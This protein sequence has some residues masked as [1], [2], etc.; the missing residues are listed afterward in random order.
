MDLKRF[1][2]VTLFF[3]CKYILGIY[4]VSHARR[5]TETK[6]ITKEGSPGDFSC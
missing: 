5:N 6:P 1:F 4:F 3:Y 2:E